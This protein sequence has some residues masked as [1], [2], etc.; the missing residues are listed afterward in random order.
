[1]D[2]DKTIH[3][4]FLAILATLLALTFWGM[5]RLMLVE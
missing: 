4:K 5:A 1:M 3:I 2:T